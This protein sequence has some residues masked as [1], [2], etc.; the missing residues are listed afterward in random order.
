MTNDRSVDHEEW[1]CGPWS[2][3]DPERWKAG[4]DGG[5]VVG[6]GTSW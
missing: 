2:S 1:A 3:F 4:I 6:L 5:W